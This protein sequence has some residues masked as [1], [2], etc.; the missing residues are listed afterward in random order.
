[1]FR[2][3]RKRRLIGLEA[4]RHPRDRSADRGGATTNQEAEGVR[5]PEGMA[6]DE[7]APW[8]LIA[9]DIAHLDAVCP[10]GFGAVKC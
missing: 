4:D 6:L 9:A 3:R 5:T 2:P 8:I 1:M 10:T 7:L